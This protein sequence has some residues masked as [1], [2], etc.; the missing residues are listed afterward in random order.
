M[1]ASP[2]TDELFETPRILKAASALG[3]IGGGG[4]S[5]PRILAA[6]CN[7][8]ASVAEVSALVELEPGLM[9]RVLR[10]ANSAFYGLSRKVTTIDR[11]LIALGLDAVRGIA[12]A[13]CLDRTVM[14]A[15]ETAPINRAAFVRHSL[16]TATAAEAVARIRNRAVSQEAFIAGLLHNLGVPVQALLDPPG[17]S[18]MIDSLRENPQQDMRE[19]E[20]AHT[21]IGHE[22]CGAVIFEAWNLAPSLVEATRHH[23]DPMA[24]SEPHRKLASL[25]H[26]GLHIAQM[27]GHCFPLEPIYTPPNA[28]ALTR[29]ELSAEELDQVAANLPDR[30]AVLQLALS[31]I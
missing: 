1:S 5:A 12:A 28:S 23:H 16:A 8:A 18:S 2:D 7:P 20:C 24:A 21:Q 15:T 4:F 11:A 22:C 31:G 25:V 14:R 19:L 9:A 3:V 17:V 6:L 26:V 29:L 30:L 27:T 10:V 13:A